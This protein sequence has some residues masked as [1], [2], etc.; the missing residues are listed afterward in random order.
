MLPLVA[1][2][3]QT[4]ELRNTSLL[5]CNASHIAALANSANGTVMFLQP[6]SNCNFHSLIANRSI[7]PC[8]GFASQFA[9][10]C[11]QARYS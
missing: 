9:L 3:F 11:L 5:Q 8:P 1:A 4:L 7:N 2:K 6:N 10:S